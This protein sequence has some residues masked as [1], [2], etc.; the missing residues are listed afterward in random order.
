M[1][2]LHLFSNY[3]WTGPAEPAVNLAAELKARG[4]DVLFASADAPACPDNPRINQHAAERGLAVVPGL[5]LDKHLHPLH[6]ARDVRTLRGLL[7]EMRPQIV[8]T[9]MRNDHFIA[10]LAV[11]A[12]P[13]RPRIVRTFYDG[14]WS[15][16]N[17]RE[18]WLLRN[19]CDHAIFCSQ[20]VRDA[21]MQRCDE[22]ERHST[23]IAGA[24]DLRRF[25]PERSLPDLRSRLNLTAADYV[26]GIVARV[27]LHRRF[28]VLIEASVIAMRA[29]PDFRLVII[30]RGTDFDRIL[31]QPARRAGIDR[32]ARFPGYL[33][34]DDY[35]G[36]L[37]ALDAK[38]FLVP[39]SDGSCRAVREAMAMGLPVITADRGMLPEIVR[40][41][42][43]GTII[44][45]TPESLAK[46]II[47]LHDPVLRARMAAAAR[48][49]AREEFDLRRQAGQVERI[50]ERLLEQG[51]IP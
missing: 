21:A 23:V 30:G 45:D 29:L 26:V 1:K 25:D 33:T 31:R 20:G 9:H 34:G 8:H 7:A 2:I 12:M 5:L 14:R 19:H 49:R 10:A 38:V 28:R 22:P 18:S 50:Y 16:W 39:G 46:A 4:H 24:V 36:C 15:A 47:E 6:A 43:T 13:E 40:D 17:L 48:D 27:Q 35:A 51:S 42:V 11:R 37:H 3:K 44:R 41:G 32:I